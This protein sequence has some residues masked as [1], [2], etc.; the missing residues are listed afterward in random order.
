MSNRN[1]EVIEENG[2]RA[3]E[4]VEEDRIERLGTLWRALPACMGAHARHC[5][6][7]RLGTRMLRRAD[8]G[9]SVSEGDQELCACNLQDRFSMGQSKVFSHLGKLK[10]AG[11]VREEKRGNSNFYSL[12]REAVQGLLGETT[13]HFIGRASLT[14]SV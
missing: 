9:V 5:A 12:V 3:P 8:L 4:G 2:S 10:D 1:L 14:A 7:G 11:L 6:R 13:E